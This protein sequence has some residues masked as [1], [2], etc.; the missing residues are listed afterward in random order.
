M[1]ALGHELAALAV[2]GGLC[3]GIL[4]AAEL[5]RAGGLGPE[6][7]RKLVHVSTGLAAAAFPWTFAS[8]WSVAALCGAFLAL[9]GW[10]RRRGRLLSVHGVGRRSEGGVSFPAAVA[11][12]FCLTVDRPA[13]YV[14]SVLVLAFADP[15]AALVGRAL[16]RRLYR[17]RGEVKSLEGSLAFLATAFPCVLGPLALMTSL[18]LRA[19]LL[20]AFL[21]ALF[22]TACE[23]VSPAGSDNATVPLGTW[24]VLAGLTG[25]LGSGGTT[26]PLLVGASL[27]AAALVLGGPRV[28]SRA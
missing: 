20:A 14:S 5:L 22:A 12:L 18:P 23:A 11:V 21:A 25:G 8:P 4:A 10:T 28:P 7:T 24:L 2:M 9:V 16:G 6:A 27:G 17:V 26:I 3:G 1:S 13:L 19:C 15:M